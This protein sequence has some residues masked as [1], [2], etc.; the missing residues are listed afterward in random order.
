VYLPL[1]HPRPTSGWLGDSP[2]YS[3]HGK[4]QRADISK[5]LPAQKPT[6]FDDPGPGAY[7]STSS[8]GKQVGLMGLNQGWVVERLL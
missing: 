6:S 8:L 3:F 1:P 4:G 7:Q 2:K 5:G